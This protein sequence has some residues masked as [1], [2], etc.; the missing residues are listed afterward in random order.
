MGLLEQS[1]GHP[2]GRRRRRVISVAP[3]VQLDAQL[4]VASNCSMVIAGLKRSEGI[5]CR[6][7]HR[8]PQQGFCC[9]LAD[10]ISRLHG[11][12]SLLVPIAAGRQPNT[13]PHLKQVG[14]G[15]P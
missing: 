7:S 1:K 9:I 3:G 2:A 4:Q 5:H 15:S 11:N 14:L 8:P 6:T 13:P 10:A 12:W